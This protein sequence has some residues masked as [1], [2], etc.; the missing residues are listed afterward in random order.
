MRSPLT[1]LAFATIA[2]ALAQGG[3]TEI[4]DARL[5]PAIASNI[6]AASSAVRA[7]GPC[8]WPGSQA[9]GIGQF[10]VSPGVGRMPTMPQNDAGIRIEQPKSVPCASGTMPVATATADPPEEPAGL[11]AGF[12]GLRVTPNTSLKVLAPAANTFN[13]VFGVTRNPWNPALSPAGSSGGSAVAVATGMVPLA[14]GTDFGCSIRMPASFC[15]IVGIRPTPGLTPNWPMPLAWDPGQ[16]H[17]PL[18]RTAED[19][20]L[21][22][23]AIA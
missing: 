6:S 9:S 5:K 2:R 14:Q 11:N 16:V 1:S 18:A 17:G 22:L 3:A 10:G 20:A 19:A 13:D 23:D 15:G 21:M 12:Q 4:G 7:R 8:T